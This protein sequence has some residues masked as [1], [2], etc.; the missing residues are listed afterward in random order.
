VSKVAAKSIIVVAVPILR[1]SARIV[2]EKGRGWSAIDEL[3]LWALSRHTLSAGALAEEIDLPRR[4]VLEVV[5]RMMRF[6]LV[7]AVLADGVPAFRSTPYGTEI[8]LSGEEIPTLKKKVSRKVA[9]VVDQITGTV[10]R[11]QCLPAARGRCARRQGDGR[12][13]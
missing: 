10:W 1:V 3:V 9:F 8:V 7:E 11:A 5:L 4:V 6:R 13:A 12:F 2:F